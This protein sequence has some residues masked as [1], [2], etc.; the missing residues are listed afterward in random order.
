M[1]HFHAAVAA[2]VHHRGDR[3]ILLAHH[4]H[5]VFAHIGVEEIARLGD[6]A[7]M[8]QKQPGAGKH[9]LQ[10]LIQRIIGVDRRFHRATAGIDQRAD[11]LLGHPVS[12][13]CG[14]GRAGSHGMD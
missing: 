10:F 12:L 6:L 2:L 13:P 11:L 7:F 8:R 4:Q 5:R 9:A 1:A 3:A 14:A